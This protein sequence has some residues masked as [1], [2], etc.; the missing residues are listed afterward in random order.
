L[1]LPIAKVL[2]IA[3][4]IVICVNANAL[5]I[6]PLIAPLSGWRQSGRSHHLLL[7]GCIQKTMHCRNVFAQMT[8]QGFARLGKL[9]VI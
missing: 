3:F 9:V 4:V 5:A 2:S 7:L 8:M 1:W 6:T